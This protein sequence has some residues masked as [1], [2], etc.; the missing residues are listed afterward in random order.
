MREIAVG[1]LPFR[2]IK[3]AIRK[4]E[5][6][7]GLL[8]DAE[9]ARGLLLGRL[10]AIAVRSKAAVTLYESAVENRRGREAA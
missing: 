5:A 9:P 4:K 10:S 1:S 8:Q 6:W 7:K 3:F 2:E